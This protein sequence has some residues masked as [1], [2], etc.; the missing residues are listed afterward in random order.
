MYAYLRPTPSEGTDEANRANGNCA[1]F[2]NTPPLTKRCSRARPPDCTPGPLGQCK[3]HPNVPS[4]P[5]LGGGGGG[6]GGG[7]KT[8]DRCIMGTYTSQSE[9]ELDI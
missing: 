6:G 9:T 8:I 7:G 5:A 2:S 3:S 1:R 4:V